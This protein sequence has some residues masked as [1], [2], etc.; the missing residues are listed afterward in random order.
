MQPT[1]QEDSDIEDRSLK[2]DLLEARRSWA[3]IATG[4]DEL[5]RE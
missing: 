3:D 4:A 2:S 1:M 5:F